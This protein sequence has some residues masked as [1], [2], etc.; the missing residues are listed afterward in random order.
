MGAA[1][2]LEAKGVAYAG[3]YASE[4][5]AMDVAEQ[6]LAEYF[7]NIGAV[8]IEETTEEFVSDD[9]VVVRMHYFLWSDYV[10]KS[11]AA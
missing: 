5:D 11:Q 1:L 2:T 4:G 6:K 9:W 3:A 7:L 10:Q 8:G